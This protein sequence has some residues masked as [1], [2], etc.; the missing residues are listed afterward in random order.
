MIQIY[1]VFTGKKNLMHI[2]LSLAK[3]IN[4]HETEDYAK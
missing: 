4:N 2:F 1:M 3:Y